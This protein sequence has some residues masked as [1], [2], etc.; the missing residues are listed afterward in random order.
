MTAEHPTCLSCGK[1]A[2]VEITPVFRPLTA[3][4]EWACELVA[5]TGVQ[6]VHS[7]VDCSMQV[8]AAIDRGDFAEEEKP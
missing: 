8:G 4:G 3:R 2:D 6:T 5:K 1:P 7:C